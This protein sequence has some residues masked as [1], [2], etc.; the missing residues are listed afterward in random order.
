MQS[1]SSMSSM[2][3][4]VMSYGKAALEKMAAPA[5]PNQVK[6]VTAAELAPVPT[7]ERYVTYISVVIGGG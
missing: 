7:I 4:S 2:L 5:D 1:S 6:A 3:N